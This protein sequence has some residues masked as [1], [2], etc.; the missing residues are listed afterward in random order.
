MSF[1]IISQQ[2]EYAEC[3]EAPRKDKKYLA[4]LHELPCV[5]TGR[6]GEGIHAAHLRAGNLAYGK[7]QSGGQ[8][9]PDD[10]WCLPLWHVEHMQHQHSMNEEDYWSL[11]GIDPHALCCALRMAYPN[12]DKARVIIKHA[13]HTR[14][15]A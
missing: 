9:K 15:A 12:T 1:R 14:K 7:P 13:R 8:Q 4:W 11:R 2:S 6:E 3:F 10:Y 5:V